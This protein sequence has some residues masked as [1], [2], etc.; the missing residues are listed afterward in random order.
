MLE[1]PSEVPADWTPDRS[2]HFVFRSR[3]LDPRTGEVRLDYVLDGLQLSETVVIPGAPF[4]LP[5]EHRAAIEGALDLLHWVAGISYW[6][7]GCP[8]HIRFDGSGPDAWQSRWLDRLYREGLA[9]FAYRNR[10]DV[11]AFP[12]FPVGPDRPAQTHAFDLARRTLVPMGGGKDSLVAWARL[13]RLDEPLASVQIGRSPLILR[14]GEVLPGEHLVI[15][16]RLDPGLARLNAMGALNGH[17]PVTAINASILVLTALLLDY[18]R[19]AF[20]NERSASEASLIDTKGRAVNH[21]FSKSLEFERMLDAWVRRFV[22]PELH[23]FSVLRRDRE[24]AI[25]REFSALPEFHGL[26]SSCNR[27]FHLDGPRV[28]RWCGACP[29]CHFV[30]LC[31]APFM[32]PEALRGIFGK[33]LLADPDLSPGFEAL[34]ALDGVK[35][36]ECVGEAEEARAAV[37]ALAAQSRWAAHPVVEH[38]EARLRGYSVADIDALCEAGGEQN[39]PGELIDAA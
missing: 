22:H 36:F 30:Y 16:R 23:V 39:L 34:L 2:H 35:P 28:Q 11:D 5:A 18:H 24:L 8:N 15:D 19:V 29:K 14:I 31:L 6:K 38:L 10:L 33:D 1:L 17:V 27:N 20:A 4:E 3:C 32:S 25:C 7:A 21:Q 26:F 13:S 12:H 9:E 37:R